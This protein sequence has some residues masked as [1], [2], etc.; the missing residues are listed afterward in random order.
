VVTSSSP[1]ARSRCTG[2]SVRRSAELLSAAA[3]ECVGVQRVWALTE[4]AEAQFRL[5]QY[6]ALQRT[7]ARLADAADDRDPE[8]RVLSCFMRGTALVVAGDPAGAAECYAEVVEQAS[9]ALL[10]SKPRLLPYRALASASLGLGAEALTHF[11]PLQEARRRGAVGILVPLLSLNA[12]G[13]ALLSDHAA[14]FA[15]AGEAAALGEHLGY[16][17]DTAVAVEMLAW[18]LA[19]RSRHDEAQLALRRATEL[20]DRAETTAA[21]SHHAI[22]AAFCA[23]CRGAPAEAAELLE[24]RIAADGGVGSMGE[25]LGV[26]PLLIEAYAALDR[27]SDAAALARRYAA[28]SWPMTTL[29]TAVLERSRALAE[30]DDDAAL[31]AYERALVLH[32]QDADRFEAART[33]LLYG[34]RLR[35][36]GRRVDARVQLRAALDVFTATDLLAWANRAAAELDATGATA[37]PRGPVPEEPLTSQ[38]SRVALLVAKGQSNKEVA[39]ALFL[40]PKTVEHHLGSVFRKRGYRSRAELAASFAESLAD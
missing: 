5:G 25:P 2:A 1:S 4:L 6:D 24:Q 30:A 35:R 20:T 14:A 34:E 31:A 32:D 38:E 39:A 15:D 11:D 29:D 8:Q 28:V 7:A 27:G 26:A 17:A 12:A 40:S 36:I 33:R 10:G 18:Q 16:A 9:H 21:H 37:R 3:D 19:A 23:L 22:T 13:R